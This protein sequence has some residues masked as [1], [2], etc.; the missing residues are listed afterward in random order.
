MTP[1][2][3]NTPINTPTGTES[4]DDTAGSSVELPPAQGS[5]STSTS[6][7]PNSHVSLP[8]DP[9]NTRQGCYTPSPF[10][11]G[12]LTRVIHS[13]QA[14][15]QAR[16]QR[17]EEI[18]N[19]MTTRIEFAKYKI[20]R[21]WA[22]LPF[23]MVEYLTFGPFAADRLARFEAQA[24]RRKAYDDHEPGSN[25][26]VVARNAQLQS[27]A[28]N[29]N[30]G[31]SE[32]S[33]SRIGGPPNGSIG[34]SYAAPKIS[35]AKDDQLYDVRRREDAPWTSSMSMKARGKRKASAW[36]NLPHQRRRIT[37]PDHGDGEAYASGS[38][39]ISYTIVPTH[40][41]P[42][43]EE[44]SLPQSY[45]DDPRDVPT[46]P[47]SEDLEPD[48]DDRKPFIEGSSFWQRVNVTS[49][50]NDNSSEDVL[51]N[52]PSVSSHGSAAASTATLALPLSSAASTA[53]LLAPWGSSQSRGR[54][55]EMFADEGRGTKARNL[56][57]IMLGEHASFSALPPPPPLEFD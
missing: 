3:S 1:T 24:K 5:Q 50:S 29:F 42:N 16:K 20:E 49:N 36:E 17:S 44:E 48:A 2:G 52:G 23:A 19:R 47:E 41:L 15:L 32:A 6:E 26:E 43:E 56:N 27:S 28:N 40:Q 13:A 53:N 55:G 35:V 11:S 57:G 38:N 21:G 51:L 10:L 46:D 33:T 22:E 8:F 39:N 7:E 4:M 31:T 18:L 30:F 54:T 37:S 34:T 25:D 12:T 14:D 9:L 45:V